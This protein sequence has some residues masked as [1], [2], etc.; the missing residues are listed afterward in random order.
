MFANYIIYKL[1][2]FTDETED[3][4]RWGIFMCCKDK[5]INLTNIIIELKGT[6]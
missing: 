4:M 5:Q 6:Y 2:I 1:Y 3:R